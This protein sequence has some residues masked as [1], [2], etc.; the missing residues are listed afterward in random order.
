MEAVSQ[1]VLA[2]S[3]P[4]HLRFMTL[5]PTSA[6]LLYHATQSVSASLEML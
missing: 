5:I 3:C 1:P 2:D 6:Y 4:W